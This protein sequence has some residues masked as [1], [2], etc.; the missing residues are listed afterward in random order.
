MQ[1]YHID[2]L[3]SLLLVFSLEPEFA[4]ISIKGYLEL[5]LFLGIHRQETL[6]QIKVKRALVLHLTL[7]VLVVLQDT[8][9]NLDEAALPTHEESRAVLVKDT[10]LFGRFAF[11]GLY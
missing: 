4:L 5:D 9:L 6:V 7:H 1:V 8:V 10:R 11:Q 3:F 2:P